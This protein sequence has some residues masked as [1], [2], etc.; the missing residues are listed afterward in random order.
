MGHGHT[1]GAVT[2]TGSHRRRLALVLA[3]T[4]I[5]MVAEVVGAIVSGSVALLADAGHMLTDA[6]GISIAL[7]AAWLAARPTTSRRTFGWQR[8]EILAALGNGLLLAVIS[9]LVLVE[10]VRRT[11]SPVEEI[12]SPV[13][14][15]VAAVGLVANAVCLT[16]LA[17][18]RRESLNV[19]GAYLEVLGDAMGSVA[20]IVAG[21]IIWQTG[22]V[23]ADGIA[24]IVIGLLILPRAASLL[25]DVGAVLLEATPVGV[26]LDQVRRH[27]Q[28]IDGVV[29][30]HDL[31]A[32]TIT[33][34]A[35]VMSAHVVVSEP[36]LDRGG[37]Q[38][39]L[40]ALRS[41]LSGHFDL[42]HSTF[43]IESPSMREREQGSVQDHP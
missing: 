7:L 26:D 22:Y 21:L 2:A 32:W 6:A 42:D 31:H 3:I 34:G 5:V 13:M 38:A 30:V 17:R 9:V 4:L 16:I 15:A 27:I 36:V 41:C 29:A 19:K 8:A 12:D 37:A 11:V 28:G 18:G 39:V 40:G 10:G 1:H 24:S 14:L 25:R 20:V 23:R 35:P 33:S 43:Q